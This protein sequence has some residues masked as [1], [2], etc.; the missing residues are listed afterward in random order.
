MIGQELSVLCYKDKKQ[1]TH[2]QF[3]GIIGKYFEN[4]V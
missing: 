1:V 2:N 4:V 3:I